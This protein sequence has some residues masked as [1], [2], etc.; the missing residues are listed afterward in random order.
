MKKTAIV[1]GTSR[2]NGNTAQLAKKIEKN[3]G[4]KIFDLSKY[5]ITAFDYEFKNKDDDYKEL[6]KEV[7]TYDNIVFASP[8]YWYTSSAHMKIFLDRIS[9]LLSKDKSLARKF[10]EKTAFVLSTGADVEVKRCFEESFIHS[11]AYLN[12]NYEGMLYLPCEYDEASE[13]LNSTMDLDKYEDKINTFCEK[14]KYI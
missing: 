3:I 11:F 5:D 2:S 12:M 13:G 14:L 1:L 8:V 4:V 6:V 9:D 7:L 10:G